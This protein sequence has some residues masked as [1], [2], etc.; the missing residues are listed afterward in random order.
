MKKILFSLLVLMIPIVSQGQSSVGYVY[1]AL[2]TEDSRVDFSILKQ[3]S[4]CYIVIKL[5]SSRVVFSNEPF[6]KMKT[7]N[8]DVI[9][10]KGFVVSSNKSSSY[11]HGYKYGGYISSSTISYA[12]FPIN[13]DE[14]EKL[15]DGII[16]IRIGTLPKVHEKVFKKDKIGEKL[17]KL[18]QKEVKMDADF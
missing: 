2:T 12:Q 7:T 10:L 13:R 17:Y 5:K 8:G 16:K 11:I 3:D 14:I 1:K 18:Y 9:D 15:K 6:L 4:L